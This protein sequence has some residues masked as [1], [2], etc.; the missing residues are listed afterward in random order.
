MPSVLVSACLFGVRCRYEGDARPDREL[1]ARLERDGC[2]VVPI[3]PEQLGGLPTPR[4]PAEITRGDGRTVL[5]GEARVIASDGADVTGQYVRGAAEAVRIAQL[6]GCRRAY[7]KEGSPACGVEKIK[8]GDRTCRGPGVA[9]A[10]LER[11][12][13]QVSGAEPGA[14]TDK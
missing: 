8:R 6:L 14:G 10:A 9:A 5:A 12:G 3:C 13:V 4:P 2:H 7:L 1:I 11:S